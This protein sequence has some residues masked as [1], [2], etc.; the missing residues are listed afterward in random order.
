[1]AEKSKTKILTIE[2]IRGFAAIYV[3]LGHIVLLYQPY[4]FVPM[5]EFPIKI[6]FGYGHE[7]VILFF[8]VSGFSIHFSTSNIDFIK[9]GCLNDYLFKR[10][11][12]LYPLFAI[13]II[14][15]FVV[16]FIA[17]IPS[18]WTRNILS[19]FFLTDISS[20]SIS[21]PIPTNFPIWSL[22]YEVV[23]YLLYPVLLLGINRFGLNRIV[24]AS[25]IISFFAGV[26][27]SFVL[28]NHLSNVLQLY[29][30]WVIGVVIAQMKMKN[31]KYSTTFSMGF[32]VVSIAFMF[33]FEKMG[34][35]RDWSWALFFSMIIISFFAKRGKISLFQKFGNSLIGLSGIA[36]CYLLTFNEA[37]AFHPQ[38]LRNLLIPF[39]FISSFISFIP[40]N[41]IQA[42]LRLILN[43]FV[44]AG[45][46]SYA[47]YIF[48]WPFILL[49]IYLFKGYYSSN[50]WIFIAIIG[51]NIG[52]V[53]LLAWYCEV[54]LQP[55]MAKILNRFYY[56]VP[57]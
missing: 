32:L 23:Y 33:T 37:V 11:R 54:L 53:F 35:I 7:A 19:L 47:L 26:F 21:D 27:G 50:I 17:Q 57:K 24:V 48:H 3:L 39:A 16:M 41:S 31:E 52:S 40:F 43:Y 56:K 34:L 6:L 18:N 42:L 13:S 15:S 20:G 55:K 8:I 4:S 2:A 46:F 38:L 44:G 5:F 14:L 9:K 49:S 12:R 45:S 10:F 29:W 1:M 28:Q 25:V 51:L 30:T 22:S 36:I